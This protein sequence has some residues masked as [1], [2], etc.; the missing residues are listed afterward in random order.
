MEFK[1]ANE[2]RDEEAQQPVDD[3]RA[4]LLVSVDAVAQ[5]ALPDPL[6]QLGVLMAASALA[7]RRVIDSKATGDDVGLNRA[8]RVRLIKAAVAEFEKKLR[9][10]CSP[11]TTG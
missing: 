7:C 11:L 5:A 1:S 8:I 2:V 3:T 6:E 9:R 10:Y 4:N